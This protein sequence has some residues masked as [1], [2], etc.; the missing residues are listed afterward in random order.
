MAPVTSM[1]SPVTRTVAQWVSGP[2]T[3][4]P[5]SHQ[6]TRPATTPG[7]IAKNSA[8]PA[9]AVDLRMLTSLRR[10]G[11]PRRGAPARR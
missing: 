7:A 5:V 8:L 2:R 10:L 6:G 4:Q 3:R 1:T 11:G 9:A